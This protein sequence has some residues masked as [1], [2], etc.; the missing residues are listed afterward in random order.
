MSGIIKCFE[1][2]EDMNEL[3]GYAMLVGAET[4]SHY[5]CP[6]CRASVEVTYDRNCN[7]I[8]HVEWDKG[9]KA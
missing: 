8:W 9:G 5:R 6:N 3:I 1:C 4:I 2:G 7:R